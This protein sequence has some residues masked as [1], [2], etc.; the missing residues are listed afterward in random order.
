[1]T[2][3]AEQIKT[4]LETIIFSN[5]DVKRI[6]AYVEKN[7]SHRKY[8]SIDIQNITGQEEIKGEP[9]TTTKQVFLVHLYVRTRATGADQ[10]PDI[11][12]TED[13]IFD[14]LDSLQTMAEFVQVVQGWDRKSETFPLARVVSTIRVTSEAISSTEGG[15]GIVGD[16]VSITLPVV[17]VLD[18]INVVTDEAGILKDLD[19][20]TASEEIFTRIRNTGLLSVEVAI[21]VSDENSIKTQIFAGSDI[22]I[23]FTKGGVGDTRTANLTTLTASGPRTEVE[24]QILTMDIKN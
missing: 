9:T 1:M 4:Q 12:A 19:L 10:E 7:E 14:S 5:I 17:G 21:S 15:E 8:P 16:K 2:L 3:T 20:T 6:N 13:Q 18:V 22:S 11:K 23:T 24:T